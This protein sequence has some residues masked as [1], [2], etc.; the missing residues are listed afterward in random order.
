MVC[1]S[2]YVMRIN[3]ILVLL[4]NLNK[5]MA[6]KVDCICGVELSNRTENF[7][8]SSSMMSADTTIYEL[9]LRNT[10]DIRIW[11]TKGALKEPDAQMNGIDQ[12][13]LYMKMHN[14]KCGHYTKD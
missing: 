6:Y 10:I 14:I 2:K 11:W 8:E 1:I 9:T 12:N 13:N 5:N 4:I 7:K 3:Y